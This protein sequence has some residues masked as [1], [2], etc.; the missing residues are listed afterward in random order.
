MAKRTRGLRTAR[1][2]GKQPVLPDPE[3]LVFQ[4]MTTLALKMASEKLSELDATRTKE[5][6]HDWLMQQA[7]QR[8]SEIESDE[9]LKAI[10]FD[11]ET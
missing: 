7:D 5:E 8:L 3:L 11:K 2:F 1:G 9:E 10:I 6:W 4:L